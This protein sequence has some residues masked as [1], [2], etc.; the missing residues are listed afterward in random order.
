MTPTKPMNTDAAREPGEALLPLFPEHSS[1]TPAG[2]LTI[3][4]VGV[5]A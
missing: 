3:G 5:S 1:V 4:G 2:E